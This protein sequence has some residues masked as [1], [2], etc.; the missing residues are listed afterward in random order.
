[1]SVAPLSLPSEGLSSRC[2]CCTVLKK[3]SLLPYYHIGFVYMF[4][5]FMFLRFVKYVWFL[6]FS[7]YIFIGVSLVMCASWPLLCSLYVLCFL[8]FYGPFVCVVLCVLLI[9]SGDWRAEL[10]SALLFLEVYSLF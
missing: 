4:I 6:N 3:P 8:F 1:M 2:S 9:V 7:C 10:I 5:I